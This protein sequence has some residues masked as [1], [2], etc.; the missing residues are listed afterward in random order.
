MA[1]FEGRYARTERAARRA[2]EAGEQ[3]GLAALLAAG[4]AELSLLVPMR[5][6]G[7]AGGDQELAALLRAAELAQRLVVDIGPV[8]AIGIGE[9]PEFRQRRLGTGE[10]EERV[11]PRLAPLLR[12]VDPLELGGEELLEIG[13]LPRPAGRKFHEPTIRERLFEFAHEEIIHQLAAIGGSEKP[14]LTSMVVQ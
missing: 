1:Y 4:S 5:A 2:F 3:P 8:A 10:L 9:A 7:P 13:L 6:G 14:V 11:H 12:K